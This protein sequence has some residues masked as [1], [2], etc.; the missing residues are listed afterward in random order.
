[1]ISLAMP[2]R[3][4]SWRSPRRPASRLVALWAVGLAGCVSALHLT[5]MPARAQ[6][7]PGGVRPVPIVRAKPPVTDPAPPPATGVDDDESTLPGDWAPALLD[8]MLSSPNAEARDSLLEAAFAAGP[9]IIPKLEASLKDDRTAEFAAQSLAFIGGPQALEIL[10]K[11]VSDPRDLSLKRFYYGALG[12]FRSPEATQALLDAVSR[13]DAEPDRSVSEAAILALSIHYDA[14][15]VPRLRQV[16]A[17]VQD[18]VIRDDLDNAIQ[19]IQERAKYLASP[20]G[21]NLSGSVD[22]AVRTY[23][24]PALEFAAAAQPAAKTAPAAAAKPGASA[25]GSHA[26]AAKPAVARKPVPPPVKVDIQRLTFSSTRT[27]ALARVTFEV[28]T[29]VAYYTFVLQKQAGDWTVASVWLGS[30]FD[31][32]VPGAAESKTTSP[33]N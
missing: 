2:G 27:R 18:Y 12:E 9:D 22:Q 24:V 28:A 17:K 4:E 33:D 21:K 1:M 31:K 10:F 14:S 13:A 32:Q 3:G 16:R 25:A 7:T 19:V 11:L 8:S 15:L 26:A 6:Q 20:K 23:F 29:A 5:A 30:E